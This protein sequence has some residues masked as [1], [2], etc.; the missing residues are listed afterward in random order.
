M[1]LQSNFYS[2]GLAL[3][4]IALI[5][6]WCRVFYPQDRWRDPI[7]LAGAIIVFCQGAFAIA[8]VFI[9]QFQCTPREAIWNKLIPGHK[10]IE[11]GPL[12]DLSGSLHLVS[13]IVIFI[14][15]QKKI[16]GLQM[17]IKKR[18]GVALVFGLGLL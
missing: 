7:F 14:I 6:E 12:Q 15:P 16:W 5:I 18:I 8:A 3:M 13:D 10:C 17:S 2:I 1:W 11:M 9:L 4:K